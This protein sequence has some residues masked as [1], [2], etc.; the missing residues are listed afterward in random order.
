MHA[1]KQ[2]TRLRN[3]LLAQ[4]YICVLWNIEDVHE[5]RPDLTDAQC[6]EVPKQCQNRHD[7][8]VGINWEVIR[9][10]A[11]DLFPEEQPAKR[12]SAIAQATGGRP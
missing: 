11:D 3:L 8:E 5:V 9:L 6:I 2:I 12:R 10:H 1:D 4:G 7:A